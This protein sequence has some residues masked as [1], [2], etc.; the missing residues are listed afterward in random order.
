MR[1]LTAARKLEAKALAD[2]GTPSYLAFHIR[3]VEASMTTDAHH[4]PRLRGT[5]AP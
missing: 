3:R 2:A 1:Q 5:A 4:A